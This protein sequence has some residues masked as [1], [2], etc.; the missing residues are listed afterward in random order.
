MASTDGGLLKS[1]DSR[2]RG[3]GRVAASNSIGA[4]RPQGQAWG[5][6]LSC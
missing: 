3:R 4:G 1:Q 5:H 2:G 6:L